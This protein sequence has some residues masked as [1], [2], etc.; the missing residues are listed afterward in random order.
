MERDRNKEND[1]D[2]YKLF[3]QQNNPTEYAQSIINQRLNEQDFNRQVF[4]MKH[5]DEMQFLNNKFDDKA[6]KLQQTEYAQFENDRLLYK[7]DVNISK[8]TKNIKKLDH[9]ETE[10]ID[11]QRNIHNRDFTQKEKDK[12]VNDQAAMI[13]SDINKNMKKMNNLTKEVTQA[14]TF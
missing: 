10:K 8:Q 13:A 6:K 9:K 4:G 12:K 2:Q 3:D 11:K 7:K 5:R 14:E 1:E